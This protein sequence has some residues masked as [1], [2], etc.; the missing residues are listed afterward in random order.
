MMWPFKSKEKADSVK[1][2]EAATDDLKQQLREMRERLL[3]DTVKAT[4]ARNDR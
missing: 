4:V 1:N 3:K 2:A